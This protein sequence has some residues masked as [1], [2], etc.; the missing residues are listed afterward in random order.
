M[1]PLQR[2]KSILEFLRARIFTI[3][4]TCCTVSSKTHI[5]S[6][7]YRILAVLGLHFD[8]LGPTCWGLF[9]RSEKYQIIAPG[10]RPSWTP[11][12]E[13]GN[14]EVWETSGRH[15]GGLGSIWEVSGRLLGR[16]WEAPG[17]QLGDIW[18]LRGHRTPRGGF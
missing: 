1:K 17:R 18:G 8:T 15:L 6:I 14:W 3:F 2:E 4:G 11:P 7:F 5:L 16:I 13:G 9:F 12:G 10:G